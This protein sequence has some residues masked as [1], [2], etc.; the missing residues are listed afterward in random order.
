MKVL[1]SCLGILLVALG[2]PTL[3]QQPEGSDSCRFAIS[4][5]M[6]R[7]TITGPQEIA[8]L[9]HVVEQPDSPVEILG[10]DFKDSQLSIASERETEQLRCTMKIRNRSDQWIRGLSIEVQV[11][12]VSGAG[13]TG[14]VGQRGHWAGL[15]P[16]QEAEVRACGGGG[17]GSAPGN[18][19]RILVY[20]GRVETG[21]CFYAPSKRIPYQLGVSPIS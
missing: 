8:T 18:H 9:V 4:G 12:S 16:G 13:G 17:N 20:V 2:R 14:F 19:V 15:A 7:P 6:A 1:I 11:A 10:V 3:I 5:V 21:D